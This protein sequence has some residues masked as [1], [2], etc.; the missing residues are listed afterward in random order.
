M[1]SKKKTTT[2]QEQLPAPESEE[3]EREPS[4][5]AARKALTFL[6]TWR[7]QLVPLVMLAIIALSARDQPGSMAVTTILVAVVAC[8]AAGRENATTLLYKVERQSIM[9]GAAITSV[10][11]TVIW[12]TPL[13][14]TGVTTAALSAL[15]I[16]PSYLWCA[17]RWPG[18]TRAEKPKQ[19]ALMIQVL[20]Q[21]PVV[22]Q[23][24]PKVLR[25]SEITLRSMSEPTPGAL[26]FS[27]D[28]ARGV[29]CKDAVGANTRHMVESL[30]ELPTDTT[31]IEPS[32]ENSRR[33][34]ITLTPER[35][36]ENVA[37]VWEGPILHE[38]GTI[39][40]AVDESGTDACAALFN[41]AGVEHAII[42]GTTG[43]GKSNTVSG[44]ILPGVL[45]G[46]ETVVYVDGGLGT[47][48]PQ[49]E[50]A[51]DW[52]AVDG[53]EQWVA[54]VDSV[55]T[56]MQERKKRRAQAGLSKWRGWHEDDPVVTL[57]IDEATTVKRQLEAARNMTV[58]TKVTEIL[59]EGRKLGVRC[60]QVAQDPMGSDVIGGRQAR[61]LAAGGGVAIGHR[62]G[63]STSNMLAGGSTSE[64]VDLR[65][66]P[67]GGGWCAVIRRGEIVSRRAR[68]RFAHDD[69]VRKA[70][71][72]FRPRPLM[73]EDR[74]AAGMKYTAQ[75]VRENTEPAAPEQDAPQPV[76]VVT[77]RQSQS[78]EQ[79]LEKLAASTK[80]LKGETDDHLSGSQR[81]AA[82]TAAANAATVRSVLDQAGAAG[83]RR[84][85]LNESLAG[86]M[87]RATITRTLAKLSEDGIVTKTDDG[88]WAST[89]ATAGDQ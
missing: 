56:L 20:E 77:P 6:W 75:T 28:L 47:S 67:P 61:E 79:S 55:H 83:I 43:V 16:W 64:P 89:R 45:N 30:L 7:W 40:L 22:A 26:T 42:T 34:K 69:A 68:V 13:E 38:D 88:V 72:G 14:V 4:A 46:L 58:E 84:N 70:L 60:I 32:R 9:F 48:A 11:A 23:D 85:A 17:S 52:W 66:L 80:R 21:W 33:I 73:G 24:G 53:V 15:L 81:A 37:A 86:Q 1:R 25:G 29:H 36:L 19:S 12:A 54:A 49:L 87:S 51:C 41:D 65:S 74:V 82:S 35:H 59:R 76:S 50:G 3:V 27:V 18:R 78:L 44:M 5:E 71:E 10:W 39:P 57:V 2:Q 62:P 8:L 63:G 31:Q